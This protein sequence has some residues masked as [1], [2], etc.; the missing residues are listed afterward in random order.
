VEANDIGFVERAIELASQ[1]ATSGGGPFGAVIA[2]EGRLISEGQNRVTATNDP[3]AHAEVVAVRLAC[4]K[5]RDFRLVGCTVYS[6][7]EPCPV[8]LASIYWS[9]AER[10][11]FAATR[12]VA[13]RAGFDDE[14]LYQE[15]SVPLAGRSLPTQQLAHARAAQPFVDWA[16]NTKKTPY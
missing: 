6:S 15:L 16:N 4:E 5:L 8:C 1:S 9:R 3:T 2:K 11:V 7:A 12:E 10:I 14:R 13:A